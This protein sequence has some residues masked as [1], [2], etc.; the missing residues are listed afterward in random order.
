[1][2]HSSSRESTIFVRYWYY[3]LRNAISTEGRDMIKCWYR[4]R[5]LTYVRDHTIKLVTLAVFLKKKFSAFLR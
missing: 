5:S 3:K 4:I 2:K 1:M